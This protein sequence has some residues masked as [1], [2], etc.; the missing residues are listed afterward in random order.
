MRKTKK[1]N[2]SNNKHQRKRKDIRSHFCRKLF[3]FF[4]LLVLILSLLMATW[5]LWMPV[6][7]HEGLSVASKCLGM[8]TCGIQDISRRIYAFLIKQALHWL[9][10]ISG[11]P[12]PI[13]IK[14]WCNNIYIEFSKSWC[15][16][17]LSI[18]YKKKMRALQSWLLQIIFLL[19][20]LKAKLAYSE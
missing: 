3:F 5:G 8:A 12:W 16:P 6:N 15:N 13:L 1:N 19:L 18:S 9:V 2:D 17:H 20:M 7:G 10:I 11:S 14:F 4:L